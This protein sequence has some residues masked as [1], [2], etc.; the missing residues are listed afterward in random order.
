VHYH[1]VSRQ[2]FEV[3]IAQDDLL[4][5]VCLYG[6]YYGTSRSWVE[7]RLKKGKHV[8]LVIDTQGAAQLKSKLKAL[9]I[10]VKPPSLQELRRR[11]NHRGTECG[12]A[13]EKR[14]AWAEREIDAAKNYD[15]MIVNDDL[16][17]AYQVLKSIVIAEEHRV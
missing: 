4:E 13:I 11:L 9:F 15:Y 1:F 3:K 16:E 7:S 14:L 8:I 2:E 12:E 5:Y 6:D 17:T 10:F